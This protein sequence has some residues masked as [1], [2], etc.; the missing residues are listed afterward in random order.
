MTQITVNGNTYS[1]DGTSSKDL[2]NGGHRNY[3]L[4]MI[5]DTVADTAAK[6]AAA[7]TQAS[8]AA[9][10]AIAAAASAVTAA[11]APG[12]NATSTTSLTIGIGAQSLTIQSGKLLVPGMPVVI[13]ST[14]SPSNY[15][16]GSVTSYNSGTGQLVVNVTNISGSGAAAAWTVSLT[17][18]PGVTGVLNELK[19]ANIASAATVNLDAATGNLVHITG[20]TGIT[21]FTLA[22]GS[23]RTVVFD[24]VLTITNSANVQC[25]AGQNITTAAGDMCTIY[26][27]G[28]GVVLL[29]D[30]I[31]KNGQANISVG[32][33][34]VTSSGNVTLTSNS[35]AA[36]SIS[37][38]AY[39]QYVT[40]PDAR[41]CVKAALLFA[42]NNSGTYPYGIKDNSG[43]IL[44][45]IPPGQ[46]VMIGLADN[47][48]AAGV[49][50]L[51]GDDPAAVTAVTTLSFDFAIFDA[52]AI[53]AN[54]S[55]IILSG[56]NSIYGMV[57]DSSSG[58]FG[59][60]TLIRLPVSS[61]SFCYATLTA[62]AGQ[63]LVASC[64]VLTA[65]EVVALTITGT[66]IALGS[67]ATA[68]LAGSAVGQGGGFV[69]LG[70]NY[71]LKYNRQTN[72]V[73]M[74]NITVSGTT[75][76]ISN[77]VAVPNAT[78]AASLF[79]ASATTAMSFD[80]SSANHYATPVTISAGL[81]AAGTQASWANSAQIEMVRA[82]GARWLTFCANNMGLVS[83]SGTVASVSTFASGLNANECVNGYVVDAQV[84]SS[85][86]FYAQST[87]TTVRIVTDSSGVASV[88][89]AQF[90]G[91]PS[92]QTSGMLIGKINSS[93]AFLY[94]LEQGSVIN[95]SGNLYSNYK[96]IEI[97]VSSATPSIVKQ[98]IFDTQF[99]SIDST[100]AAAPQ[101][102]GALPHPGYSYRGLL[103]TQTGTASKDTSQGI[104]K[105]SGSPQVIGVSAK[106]SVVMGGQ[107]PLKFDGSG[108]ISYPIASLHLQPG[109]AS[110]NGA[111][112]RSL[113]GM[114]VNNNRLVA[115]CGSLSQQRTFFA[116]ECA[117]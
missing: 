67:P 9:S 62:T 4:P 6:V 85:K 74:R 40:L 18:V 97:D 55:L 91:A 102:P 50:T 79:A 16:A 87:S 3:L 105:L 22:S 25:P 95:G 29:T 49:W 70:S 39:G 54:R 59:A 28:A 47:V 108:A 111:I 109:R 15:M 84:S 31:R 2:Q 90:I 42:I 69:S 64:A 100:V 80:Y 65:L 73:G 83:L 1:D 23:R 35:A 32:I 33:G 96:F 63:V 7:G 60:P 112:Y 76:L 113:N 21:A 8:N 44:G 110:L 88:A 75:P 34:G 78:S 24:G 14:A 41:N 116:V 19:A 81:P 99:L 93:R 98:N 43:A 72:V 115:Q 45:W 77:E 13:A 101:I 48:G 20:T 82:F 52:L 117:A 53:D 66:S 27:D 12:T 57:L 37:S 61:I 36:Q 5:S 56:P 86:W 26:G 114:H 104:Q 51:Y 17:G 58:Q 71:L 30:Y 46:T 106:N 94:M 68:T 11:N 103:P 92:N 10:S 107:M 89:S 38:T